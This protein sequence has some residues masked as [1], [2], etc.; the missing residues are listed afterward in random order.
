VLQPALVLFALV[1]AHSFGEGTITVNSTETIEAIASA[2][3]YV[4]VGLRRYF[5]HAAR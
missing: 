3:G 2:A 1:H 5:Y 4:T